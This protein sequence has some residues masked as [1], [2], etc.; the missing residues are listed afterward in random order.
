MPHVVLIRRLI[1]LVAVA[2]LTFGVW[3]SLQPASLLDFQ[4]VVAWSAQL[5]G[6]ASPYVG[7]S[8]TDYPPWA[9]ITLSPLTAIPIAAQA[10]LW[11]ALNVLLA[12]VITVLLVRVVDTS[13]PMQSLLWALLLATGPFRVLG[14]FSILSFALALSGAR[15]RSPVTGGVLLGLGLMKPQVGG[16]ILLAHV[17]MRDWTRV[18][19]AVCVP[20]VLTLVAGVL[21]STSPIQLLGDYVRVLDVVHGADVGLPGHTDL[22]AWL[23]PLIP[24]VTTLPGAAALAAILLAPV[25]VVAGRHRGSWTSDRQLE[26]YALCG[27]VSLLSA[28]HLSYDFLLILPV[29]VAW[30]LGPRLPW[31]ITSGLL[32]AQVPGW[33]RR[34]FEPMGWPTELG[35]MLELDR[36]LCLALFGLLS[37]RLIRLNVTE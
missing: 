2:S 3:K 4:R 11:V 19:V 17:F 15:H 1:W 36:V 13:P 31:L 5:D 26:L 29:V 28:R 32:I 34:V 30:R 33:W 18:G 35:L 22:K 9:L 7:E 12:G 23:A 24:V 27:V 20:L 37:W 16:A 6:G 10:P 14:Q 25:A 21:T 8:E